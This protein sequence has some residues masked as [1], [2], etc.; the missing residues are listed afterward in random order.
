MTVCA[1]ETAMARKSGWALMAIA[2]F[3]I[4]TK[5]WARTRGES[6]L[7][8]A[9]ALKKPATPMPRGIH[10]FSMRDD[11]SSM[12]VRTGMLVMSE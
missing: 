2:G 4:R 1:A 6:T 5:G 3:S 12:R 7:A 9:M 10:M 11:A 8:S